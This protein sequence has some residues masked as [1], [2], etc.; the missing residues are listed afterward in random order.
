MKR[1]TIILTASILLL[2]SCAAKKELTSLKE[3]HAMTEADLK[4]TT[5]E[6]SDCLKDKNRYEDDVESLEEEVDYLKSVNYKLLENA[7]DL[8]TLSAKE[9]EN[10]ERSLESLKE[11][12]MQIRRMQDALTK[13]DSVT[14]ALVQYHSSAHLLSIIR[15]RDVQRYMQN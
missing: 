3:T 6:L 4:T 9:A 11:K 2:S 10:L 7:G 8:A 13:K 5:L 12:D 15:F 14:L 1:I